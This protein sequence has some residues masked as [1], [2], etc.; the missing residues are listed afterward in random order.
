MIFHDSKQVKLL[1]NV[2]NDGL[3]QNLYKQ[4]NFMQMEKCYLWHKVQVVPISRCFVEKQHRQVFAF[5]FSILNILQLLCEQYIETSDTKYN[6]KGI[7]FIKTNVFQ[8][9]M[10]RITQLNYIPVTAFS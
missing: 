1:W 7:M 10:S 2:K 6:F 5:F 8:E 4:G 3:C 9:P